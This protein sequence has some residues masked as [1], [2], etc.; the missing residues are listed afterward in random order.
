MIEDVGYYSYYFVVF[1]ISYFSIEGGVTLL[2]LA[3]AQGRRR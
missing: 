1:I 2:T 3:N